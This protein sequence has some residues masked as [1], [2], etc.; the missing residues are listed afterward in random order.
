M[1][2]PGKTAGTGLVIAMGAALVPLGESMAESEPD[3]P[4]PLEE[5]VVVAT[6]TE[7]P[8]RDV[9]ASV[10]VVDAQAVRRSRALT[11]DELF[12]SMAGV[13]VQD[14]GI[15]GARP[16]ISLR[17]LT[18]GFGTKRVLAL[19]DGRRVN[20][21]YQGSADFMMLPA[22]AIERI[23]MLR[24]PAS[25]L[26]G[27]NAMGGVINIVTRRGA[28]A[29]FTAL[30]AAAGT[31]NTQRIQFSHGSLAGPADVLVA[32]SHMRTDGHA[33]TEAGAKQDWEASHLLARTGMPLGENA[34]LVLGLG[35][36]RGR[37]TDE[38]AKRKTRSDYQMATYNLLWDENQDAQL[39]VRVYRNGD[40]HRYDWMYPGAGEYDQETWAVEAQ[41]SLWL[42]ARQQLV[43]GTEARRESVDIDE[44]ATDI[45]EK[46][47]TVG[48]YVQ[49]EIHAREDLIVTAGIRY[50]ANE[51]FANSWSPRLGVLW[52]VRE[53]AELYSSIHRAHRAPAL[54]DRFV[55]QRFAGRVFQGNPDLDPETLT[56]YEL[57][58]RQ[59]VGA[60]LEGETALF[61]NHM[62]DSFDFMMDP[63]GVFRN[64]NA[65]RTIS[66]GVETFLRYTLN[67]ALD[68]TVSY[69]FT[70]GEYDRFE[71]NP[72]VEGNRL[73]YL[74]R[75]KA[76]VEVGGTGPLNGAHSVRW[77]YVGSR[78]G[79]AA[80]TPEQKMDAY[81]TLD[82]RTRA[83]VTD[84]TALTL[85]VDNVL[86]ERYRHFPNVE[87]PGRVLMVG[88]EVDW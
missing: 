32:G 66:Y 41:Q 82:W 1:H 24:G 22:D 47:D 8:L 29:P 13:D 60:N 21:A 55:E 43:L 40:W 85:S 87:R 88:M 19:V 81:T 57:G 67:T 58:W 11:A 70:E 61:Y 73:A 23:E 35:S 51:D 18:P 77:R 25:A 31:H 14:A 78:H 49:D 50:D 65:T 80:N 69:A 7:K 10:R 86:A 59:R 17:G 16:R 42:G 46:T 45:D 15:F 72:R 63:D 27:S 3:R 34:E 79:D 53:Q 84:R 38:D 12:L 75:H 2:F 33:R 39:T 6:R 37:G 54:S 44:V 74:A 20:D 52:R 26:Y 76:A 83:P 5:M 4:E 64:R 9:P 56:A 28:E 30:R 71:A 36:F 62:K 48:L 68:L